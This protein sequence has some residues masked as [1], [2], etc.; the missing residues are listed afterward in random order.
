MFSKLQISGSRLGIRSGV[1]QHVAA[2]SR[3]SCD[4][5][6]KP[7]F[8][9]RTGPRTPKLK[10]ELLFYRFD[11][12]EEFSE[13]THPRDLSFGFGQRHRGIAK[14]NPAG[15]VFRDTT[16]CR[17]NCSVANRNV[18]HDTD[19]ASHCYTLSNSS[20]PRDSC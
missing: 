3:R 11:S 5:E 2:F 15:N 6:E 14:P 18:T 19:L 7:Y 20:A 8:K 17:K 13:P 16:L 10:P 12:I 4:R 1:R 9:A